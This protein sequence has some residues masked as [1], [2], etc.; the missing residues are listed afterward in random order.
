[1]QQ[2]GCAPLLLCC[3]NPWHLQSALQ[4]FDSSWFVWYYNQ[5]GG[6]PYDRVAETRQQGGKKLSYMTTPR[7]TAY[8]RVSRGLWMAVPML[9][10][11]IS[12]SRPLSASLCDTG[13]SRSLSGLGPIMMYTVCMF[14]AGTSP[15]CFVVQNRTGRHT[16][17][18]PCRE[19]VPHW[20]YMSA[21]HLPV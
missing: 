17:G 19:H 6:K 10:A 18:C 3:L 5:D 7:L 14:S 11:A 9:S 1:M 21:G 12:D 15:M 8:A 4:G 13:C 2:C 20:Q 16:G